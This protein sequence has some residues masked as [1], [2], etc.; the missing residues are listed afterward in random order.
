MKVIGRSNGVVDEQKQGLVKNEMAHARLHTYTRAGRLIR[1]PSS[2][3]V[4]LSAS[5]PRLSQGSAGKLGPFCTSRY[6]NRGV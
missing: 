2:S 4:V 5:A 3:H 1:S 6:V